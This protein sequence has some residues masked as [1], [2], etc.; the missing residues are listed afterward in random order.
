M[1]MD[2]LLAILISFALIYMSWVIYDH[3]KH[4]ERLKEL[5]K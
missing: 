5:R 4:I 1:I 2:G 3:K